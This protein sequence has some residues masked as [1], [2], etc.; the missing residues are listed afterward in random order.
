MTGLRWP[1]APPRLE[2]RGVV[3]RGLRPDDADAV[4]A[5]CQ[6]AH[7]Q[8]WTRVPSPYRR[9]D[10]AQFVETL[11]GQ[12]WAAR[13]AAPFAVATRDDALIGVC[14]I[15]SVD[16]ENLIAEIGYWVA[17]GAR[18]C[19]VAPT[20]AST[21]AAWALDEVGFGRVELYV[22]PDNVASC[23]VAEKMGCKREGLLRRR[24]LI[25]GQR[26]DAVLYAMVS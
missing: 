24:T 11:S 14:G 7:I 15:V 21:I 1:G 16:A 6:D 25:R 22:D 9:E 4:F 13:S 23:V 5:A 12:M 19:G 2:E 18:G 20:A 10:A 3:L 26:R 17:P 8:R